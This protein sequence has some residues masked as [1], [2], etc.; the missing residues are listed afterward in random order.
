VLGKAL[1]MILGAGAIALAGWLGLA[2]GVQALPYTL[3]LA[4]YAL[5]ALMAWLI[6]AA[7]GGGAFL[8]SACFSRTAPAAGLG[9][10]WTLVSFVLDV[11]PF[12]AASAIAPLNPWNH[13][14]P[15]AVIASGR[16]DPLG[17]AVLVAWAVAGIAAATWVFGKRDLA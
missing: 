15:Q 13:Y 16:I 7:L 3:P 14:F 8:I 9:A 1:E 4:G 5:A 2:L 12:V 6:F 17:T 10:A 11:I